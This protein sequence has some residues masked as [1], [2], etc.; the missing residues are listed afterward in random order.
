MITDILDSYNEAVENQDFDWALRLVSDPLKDPAISE[1]L[2]LPVQIL[3][4]E[5][6][7]KSTEEN[8]KTR[9]EAITDSL[10]QIYNRGYFDAHLK[11]LV[12]GISRGDYHQRSGGYVAIV[13]IDTDHFKNINDT[14]G[15]PFGDR[16]L[17][18][19]ANNIKEHV[20]DSDLLARY[21]GEEFAVILHTDTKADMGLALKRL[22]DKCCFMPMTQDKEGLKVGNSM[23]AVILSQ[24]TIQDMKL[25]P[26]NLIK[27]ADKKLYNAKDAGRK[28]MKCSYTSDATS[29][30]VTYTVVPPPETL[31]SSLR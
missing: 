27:I 15:H 24:K 14:H 7:K 13:I 25:S 18:N 30:P 20:R 12:A 8:I 23:G 10:T 22:V 1:K 9:Q 6:L 2:F 3:S 31:S 19:V 29:V 11:D 4:L 5:T 28:Q 21:G 16:V 26:E 17:K